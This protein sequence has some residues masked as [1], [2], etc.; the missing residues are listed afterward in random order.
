MAR[1]LSK[2]EVERRKDMS[3]VAFLP[4]Y[5]DQVK[6]IAM[7]G[8]SDGEMAEMF[9]V[10]K[11]LFSAWKRFYPGFAEAIE[12][13]RTQADARVIQALFEKA[14][15]YSHPDTKIVYDKDG[16][17]FHTYEFTRH[18]PPSDKAIEMWLTNRQ[19]EHW[20]NRQDHEVSG[21]DGAPLGIEVKNESKKELVS[22]ILAL[23]QPKPDG[24]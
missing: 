2:K 15:G 23:I 8:L 20:K 21:K 7:R 3:T 18:Y 12:K 6:A 10:S 9:G 19:K 24:E 14:T 22:S 17:G 1:R 4:D 13:G 11:K 5:P 16:G